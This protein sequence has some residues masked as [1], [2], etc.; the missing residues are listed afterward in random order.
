MK[1]VDKIQIKT[2]DATSSI[3]TFRRS[4]FEM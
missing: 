1:L 3:P 2:K 4:C